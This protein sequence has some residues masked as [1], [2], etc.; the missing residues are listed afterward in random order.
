[1]LF[2]F[3]IAYIFNFYFDL[4]SVQLFALKCITNHLCSHSLFGLCHYSVSIIKWQCA[5][6][7]HMERFSVLCM[8]FDVRHLLKTTTIHK[9]EKQILC[10]WQ[11]GSSSSVM[12]LTYASDIMGQYNKIGSIHFKSDPWKFDQYHLYSENTDLYKKSYFIMQPNCSYLKKISL[13][14]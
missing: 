4:I 2:L 10:Y 13:W 9:K 11:R 7:F 6:L 1:M 12:P 14:W 5:Q 3:V 8:Y